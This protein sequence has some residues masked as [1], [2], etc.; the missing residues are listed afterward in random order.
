MLALA[1]A[2]L[3]LVA[4]WLELVLLVALAVDVA[5]DELDAAASGP[6]SLAEVELWDAQ[7]TSAPATMV[8]NTSARTLKTNGSC[9]GGLLDGGRRLNVNEAMAIGLHRV[10]A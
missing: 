6:R 3:E 7:P 4:E 8:D 9:I 1:V 2:E 10:R 5:V